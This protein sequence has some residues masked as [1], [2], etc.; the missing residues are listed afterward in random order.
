MVVILLRQINAAHQCHCRFIF[1]L[2]H[3]DQL[4][5]RLIVI[6]KVKV[7]PPPVIVIL[8]L[9]SF[10]CKRTLQILP[11]DR[12]QIHLPVCLINIQVQ[13]II[14]RHQLH[15]AVKV[16][17]GVFLIPL[18]QLRCAAQIVCIGHAF[19]LC[20]QD[21]CA[22]INRLFIFCKT[23]LDRRQIQL[24]ILRILRHFFICRIKCVLKGCLGL[25]I[26]CQ[27]HIRQTKS[28]PRKHLLLVFL[29]RLFK[30]LLRLRIIAIIKRRNALCR[31]C[32][33]RTAHRTSA[34]QHGGRYEQRE[35]FPFSHVPF[36]SY[37]FSKTSDYLPARTCTSIC[38]NGI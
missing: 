23:V 33:A 29:H 5:L 24:Q 35:P 6:P 19:F 28:P 31:F 7:D 30:K 15:C 27:T 26:L 18:M 12:R 22:G 17:F 2:H 4:T 21:L 14:I 16:C 34:K 20:V 1:L 3:F 37:L 9:C 10:D 32:T 38:G 13:I 11:A 25:F 36:L 8:L